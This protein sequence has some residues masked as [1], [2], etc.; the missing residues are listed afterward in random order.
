MFREHASNESG[1]SIKRTTVFDEPCIQRSIHSNH[2]SCPDR[3]AQS[4]LSR[5]WNRDR[6]KRRLRR[7]CYG[8][9][10]NES[11]GYTRC[12]DQ[13][14]GYYELG[15]CRTDRTHFSGLQGFRPFEPAYR[16]RNAS[17]HSD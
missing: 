6:P 13:S 11:T 16:A 17:N 8:Y 1:S 9:G 15:H 14:G 7:R 5:S 10:G 2:V 4:P 12:D 3:D